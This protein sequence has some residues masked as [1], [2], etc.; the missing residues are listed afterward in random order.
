M[1]SAHERA[2]FRNAATYT[3]AV[4][5]TV[6]GGK[7]PGTAERRARQVAE[8]LANTAARAADVVEA[9]AT[10]APLSSVEAVD[11]RRVLFG[12]ANTGRG[13]TAEPDKLDRYLDPDH[14]LAL[15]SL[16]QANTAHRDYQQA[17][18]ARRQAL[19][20]RNPNH[21]L[22]L[23]EHLCG[24]VYC[25]PREHAAAIHDPGGADRFAEHRCPCGQSVARPG[26]RC[27]HHPDVTVVVLEGDPPLLHQLA[28]ATGHQPHQPPPETLDPL[29][30]GLDL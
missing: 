22:G 9:T 23:R 6:R 12:E 30:P 25:Q 2:E 20:C 19:E 24:C 18:V 26:G 5:I 27:P 3:V 21:A 17:D 16:E 11:P 8:R 29:D 28:D 4:T 15:R 10:A 14:E 7:R 1:A 13:T